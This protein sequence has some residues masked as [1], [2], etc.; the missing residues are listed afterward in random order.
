MQFET[1]VAEK[2]RFRLTATKGVGTQ[3]LQRQL[4][5]SRTCCAFP[6]FSASRITLLLCFD[7]GGNVLMATAVLMSPQHKAV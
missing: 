4:F 1:L 3:R 5:R 7:C 6:L 2:I